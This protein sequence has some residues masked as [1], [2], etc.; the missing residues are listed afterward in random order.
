MDTPPHRV[1]LLNRDIN[2]LIQKMKCWEFIG[3]TTFK[4]FKSSC[5]IGP[6]QN[7]TVWAEAI[8]TVSMSGIK[9]GMVSEGNDIKISW[10]GPTPTEFILAKLSN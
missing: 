8:L 9:V 1:I 5:I 4:T 10:D 3:C 2:I 6:E 7:L